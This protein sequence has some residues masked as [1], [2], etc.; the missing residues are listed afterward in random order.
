MT[1]KKNGTIPC[2]TIPQSFISKKQSILKQLAVPDD[3]YDDLSPKGSV[4]A[5]ITDFVHELNTYDGLV[6][7]SSCSGRIS[8]FLEGRKTSVIEQEQ[9]FDSVTTPQY[10]A[11]KGGKGGGGRWLYVSHTPLSLARPVGTEAGKEQQPQ[12]LHEFFQLQRSSGDM[13][14]R[15]NPSRDRLVHLKFEPMVSIYSEPRPRTRGS[16]N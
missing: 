6:T 1:S 11:S 12:A 14:A 9:Q 2:N 3:Q 10:P 7:T 16:S 15:I 13:A 4:D 8:V 5:E